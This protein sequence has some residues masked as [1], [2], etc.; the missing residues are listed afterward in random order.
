MSELSNA[1]KDHVNNIM[2]KEKLYS[3]VCKVVS[4]DDSSRT[5]ELEPVNGDAE[6]TGRLQASL[7]LSEGVYIKPS[8]DSFVLLS[9][10]NEITGVITQFSEIDEIDI[11]IGPSSL[12][13]VDG[14][15]TFNGGNLGGLSVPSEVA[16]RFNLI[17]QDINNLKTAF[18]S[19]VTAPG[20]G[21]AAL[22][23][24]TA[25]WYGSQLIQTQESDINNEDILQ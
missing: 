22:K 6:R 12:N 8:V 15:V 25:T 21:G 11:T 20:D 24:I 7:E 9:W 16:T 14:Q 13:V 17:E 2:S 10:I 19:W 4:V 5:C 1:I 3:S 18:S 23:A